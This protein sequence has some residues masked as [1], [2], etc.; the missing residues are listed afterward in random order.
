M[1]A[2]IVYSCS[3][4]IDID[5]KEAKDFFFQFPELN[6]NIKP[7]LIDSVVFNKKHYLEIISEEHLIAKGDIDYIKGQLVSDNYKIW[8]DSLF[9]DI[10]IV[11]KHYI[12]SVGKTNPLTKTPSYIEFSKPYFSKDKQY[13]FIYYNYY[14]G[15]LCAE[16]TFKL[17]KK[18]NSKWVCIKTY[19]ELVS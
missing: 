10:K 19:F 3:K 2:G 13:C 9:K 8:E 5:K 6:R 17:Y 18:I 16:T 7:Y 1:L 14:C 4:P 12:D 15:N 11:S